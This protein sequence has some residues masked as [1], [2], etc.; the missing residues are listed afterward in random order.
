MTMTRKTRFYQKEEGTELGAVNPVKLASL[1]IV[2]NKVRQGAE[3]WQNIKV[4]VLILICY[5]PLFH[6]S[7]YSNTAESKFPLIDPRQSPVLYLLGFPVAIIKLG[8]VED[9]VKMNLPEENG[10]DPSIFTT[11]PMVTSDSLMG[12]REHRYNWKGDRERRFNFS[13]AE[14]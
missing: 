9:T 4:E 6:P 2:F 12:T 7:L 3:T 8:K 5:L 14:M 1:S 13:S 10:S 11:Y